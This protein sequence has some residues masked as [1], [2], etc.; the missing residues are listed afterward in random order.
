MKN[1]PLNGK[2]RFIKAVGAA[3]AGVF[4]GAAS[5]QTSGAA[6]VTSA[7]TLRMASS[8]PTNLPLLHESAVDFAETVGE[9]SAGKLR[10]EV[11]DPSKHG[12]PAGILDL[13]RSG[14]FDLG[15]TTAQYYAA[16]L[17]PIDFFTAVPFGLVALEQHA[18]MNHG[19]GEALMNKMLAPLGVEALVAGNTGVQMGGWFT[20]EVRTVGDLRGLRIRINGFPGRVLA[21]VGAEPVGLPLGQVAKSFESASIDA[22]DIVG[23]AIDQAMGVAKFAPFY[24]LPWHE[25]DVALHL[26]M[27]RERVK[28]LPAGTAAVLRHAAHAAA[29]R[30]LARAQYRNAIAMRE[31]IDQ[32]VK[33]RA[34]PTDVLDALRKATELELAASAE[35]DSRS[36]EV[37]ES[38]RQNARSMKAYA[39]IAEAPALVYR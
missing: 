39:A 3:S 27:N 34:L 28:G 38:W 7:I 37:I 18:W 2:R 11:V 35:K 22:A 36:A 24:Y 21:R 9:L 14:D 31:L 15:H 23:P 13:V 26:F 5:A 32:G 6:S 19:G 12:K 20:K 1:D 16:Q 33:V 29:L 4:A 25:Y 17:P 8:W 30:S 10:I